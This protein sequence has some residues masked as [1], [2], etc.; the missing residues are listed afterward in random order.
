M[1]RAWYLAQFEKQLTGT[2]CGPYNCNMA[3]AAMAVQQVSLGALDTNA[4]EMRLLS[5]TRPTCTDHIRGNEGTDIQDAAVAMARKGVHLTVY[6]SSDGKTL[7]GI[8]EALK[9]GRFA[10]GH[11][12]YD[13]VPLALR[14]DKDYLG[15]HSAFFHE[16]RESVSLYNGLKGPAVRVGDGLNDGRRAGIPNGFVWWPVTVV[17]NYMTK[18]PGDGLTYGLLDLRKVV[19][20]VSTANVRAS[21]T[22]ESEILRTISRGA[23]LVWGAVQIG[24]SVGGDRRWYRVW[25]PVT[26]KVGFM[27]A[28]VVR[29]I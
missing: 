23:D 15:L 14:G 3:A 22:T 12:D 10:I 1:G 5:G 29:T 17:K 21:T 8:I 4:D 18:F 27:H 6:D 20:R 19:V 7:E 28:S 25:E 11:G 16:Y 13:Q 24:Q 26:A 9:I 2:D